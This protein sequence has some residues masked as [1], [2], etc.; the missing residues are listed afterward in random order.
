MCAVGGRSFAAVHI[1]QALSQ[2][3]FISI[4]GGFNT[5]KKV[6]PTLAVL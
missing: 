5:L 2:N 6:D 3:K 1:L 4:A